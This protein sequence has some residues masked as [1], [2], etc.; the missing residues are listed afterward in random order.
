MISLFLKIYSILF[1]FKSSIRLLF[2]KQKHI[3][4]ICFHEGKVCGRLLRSLLLYSQHVV[5]RLFFS[6]GT[7]GWWKH[8]HTATLLLVYNWFM[9]HTVTILLVYNWFMYHTVTILLVYNWFIYPTVTILL[10]YN[11]FIYHTVTLLLV[12]NWFIYLTATILLVYNWFIYLTV[13]ILLVY[14]WFIY[15]TVQFII[16]IDNYKIKKLLLRLMV[17][18][19]RHSR[20]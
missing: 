2:Y 8:V 15:I 6:R 10:V 1:A 16:E 14:N 13:T 4:I 5:R 3:Y 9:Y 11:W 17:S 19:C 20:L 18:P 12:Y 7:D